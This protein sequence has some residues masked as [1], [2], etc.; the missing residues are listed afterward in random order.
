MNLLQIYLNINHGKYCNYNILYPVVLIVITVHN[1]ILYSDVCTNF[2]NLKK[3][4][5]SIKFGIPSLIDRKDR[6]MP[7]L[8]SYT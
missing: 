4:G 7:N 3:L 8:D 5:T 6:R 2:F 1:T